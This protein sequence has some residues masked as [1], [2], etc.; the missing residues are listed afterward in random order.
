MAQTLKSTR[1]LCQTLFV[2]IAA[3]RRICAMAEED[4]RSCL[5]SEGMPKK[6]LAVCGDEAE[7]NKK[8]SFLK[9]CQED[10]QDLSTA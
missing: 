4:P 8:F 9:G 10:K 3:G 5:W 6:P 1:L 2:L 7:M